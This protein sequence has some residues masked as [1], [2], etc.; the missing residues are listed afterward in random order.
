MKQVFFK[1]KENREVAPGVFRMEL[2]G[3]TQEVTAP[4]QFVNVR[5]EGRYL[6]RPISVCDKVDNCHI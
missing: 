3:D 4:G 1:V 2:E 6:R 5:L